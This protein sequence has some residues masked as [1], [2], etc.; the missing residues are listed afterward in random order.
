MNQNQSQMRQDATRQ[1]SGPAIGLLVTGIIGGF[2]SLIGMIGL[3]LGT[4]LLSLVDVQKY[5]DED[6]PDFVGDL[7]E[8][9]FGIG[10]SF[11]GLIIAVFI[12]YFSLKMK[13]LKQWGLAVAVSIAAMLPCISPCCII[14]LPVGIW[15]LV[16]LF[17]PEVRSAF[18]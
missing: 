1:V 7:Y 14:G 11:V 3:I 4:G 2:F 17:R 5:W 10:P 13:D 8:G 12:I 18:D 16:I 6:L 9:A 15:S